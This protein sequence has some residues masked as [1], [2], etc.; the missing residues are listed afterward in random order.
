MSGFLFSSFFLG[1]LFV[2]LILVFGF[3]KFCN[4]KNGFVFGVKPWKHE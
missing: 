4:H 2:G 3:F 1:F